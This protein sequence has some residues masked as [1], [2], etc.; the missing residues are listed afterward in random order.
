MVGFNPSNEDTSEAVL[1][2]ESNDRDEGVL[3]IPL[4]GNALSVDDP[5][6]LHPSAF[7]LHPCF[8]NPFNSTTLITYEVPEQIE[9]NLR[10]F[11][12]EGREVET[13]ES[14]QREAGT[15][16]IVWNADLLPTGLYFCRMEAPGF[17]RVSKLVLTK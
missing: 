14:S 10:I 9:V 17:N 13:L 16:Q 3:D 1:R 5:F 2:I 6:I 4:S 11:D 8:P 12:Q 15:Y 7:I